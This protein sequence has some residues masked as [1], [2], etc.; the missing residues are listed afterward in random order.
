MIAMAGLWLLRWL[1][2]GAS[3]LAVVSALIWFR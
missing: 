3:A 1:G 2:I